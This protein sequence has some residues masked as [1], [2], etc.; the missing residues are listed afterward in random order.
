VVEKFGAGILTTGGELDR[1]ALRERI[2]ADP[3]ARWS[4]KPFF[5]RSFERT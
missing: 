2:F 3:R 5:I 1:R 4:S